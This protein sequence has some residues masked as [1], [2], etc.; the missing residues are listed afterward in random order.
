M[1]STIPTH[2]V[3]YTNWLFCLQIRLNFNLN[4][5]FISIIIVKKIREAHLEKR[6]SIRIRGNS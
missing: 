6:F 5:H 2:L 4:D 1:E 3:L